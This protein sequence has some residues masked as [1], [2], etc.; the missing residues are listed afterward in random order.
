MASILEK[1]IQKLSNP[2]TLLI[3]T[4]FISQLFLL[5][6]CFSIHTV[7]AQP[8][9]QNK[10]KDTTQLKYLINSNF[11]MTTGNENN[12]N[13][14]SQGLLSYNRKNIGFHFKINYYYEEDQHEMDANEFTTDLRINI[15]PKHRLYGFVNSGYEHSY[16]RLHNLRI[17][18]G[19][20]IAYRLLDQNT[21]HLTPQIGFLYEFTDYMSPLVINSTYYH[22]RNS[23][24]AKIGWSGAHDLLKNHLHIRHYLMYNQ[25]IQVAND[26]RI[27][28]SAGFE[29]PL[30][31]ILKFELGAS[32]N[33]ENIVPINTL[34][35]DFIF[36]FGLTVANF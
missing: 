34:N 8:S 4:S 23:F 19:L 20:G 2:N 6:I 30:Y 9:R 24:R 14:Y 31:K 33:Y 15:L 35:F 36:Y 1:D 27:R 17:Y 18:N 25:S 16:L 13:T 29:V 5:I 32:I 3:I 22:K 11:N 10:K 28:A 12:I 21:Q 7:H 26:F